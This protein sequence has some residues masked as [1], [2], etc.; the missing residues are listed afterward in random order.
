MFPLQFKFTE[1]ERL[2][3]KKGDSFGFFWGHYGVLGFD[4][5]DRDPNDPEYNRNHCGVKQTP[6][7][8]TYI[9]ASFKD[10]NDKDSFSY[11]DYA[12]WW[13]WCCK[14]VSFHFCT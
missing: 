10:V 6:Q 1:G 12:I 4:W 7:T 5:V 3:V 11:R 13:H 9:D 14:S 2:E 8:N